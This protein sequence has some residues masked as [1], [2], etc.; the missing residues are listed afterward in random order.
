MFHF[1]ILIMNDGIKDRIQ[2]I[3]EV[4]DIS[5]AQIARQIGVRPQNFNRSLN[6]K[7][8]V[9]YILKISDEF[10][11]SF[12]WLN[13][14]KGDMFDQDRAREIEIKDNSGSVVSNTFNGDN[15]SGSQMIHIDSSKEVELLKQRVD[16]LT[17]IISEKDIQLHDKDK[18]LDD[19]DKQIESQKKQLEEKDRQI[20]MMMELLGKSGGLAGGKECKELIV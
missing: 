7:M 10:H 6:G 19:K 1:N 16:M 17:K 8:S 14:G 5:E 9:K 13:E 15:N 2:K 12:R 3:R 11:V 4:F 20:K 18:R